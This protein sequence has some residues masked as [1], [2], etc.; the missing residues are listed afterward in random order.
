MQRTRLLLAAIAA[1]AAIG[2]TATAMRQAPEG[3]DA[4]A[5]LRPGG[6]WLTFD[7][8][9]EPRG[10][11]LEPRFDTDPAAPERRL[12]HRDWTRVPG[13]NGI[14]A[15]PDFDAPTCGD[16]HI[17]TRT[18]RTGARP[19]FVVR[20]AR[21]ADRLRYGEQVNTRYLGDGP[22]EARVYIDTALETFAYPDGS[23]RQLARPVARAETRDGDSIPVVLRTA[24]LL[25]GWGLLE[26]IEPGFLAH[27]HDPDDRNG[28]GIS[29]R[30]SRATNDPQGVPAALGWK[31]A[32]TSVQ[33]QVAAALHNDMGVTSEAPAPEITARELMLLTDYVRSLGVP[34]RRSGATDRGRDLF[35]LTGCADCHVSAALT[36]KDAEPAV[37]DQLIW[38][39]SDFM[40][41]DMGPGLADPGDAPDAAEWRTAPLW[42][43]GYAETHMP[44]RGFLH[45]GRARDVEEAV[46]WHGGEAA[47]SRDA[48][49]ALDAR[50]RALLLAYVRAL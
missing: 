26:A 23:E 15:G 47:A 37:A 46:L 17:E 7:G 29:G 24:P 35:G 25:Y 10:A 44:E 12:Y 20:P 16:C 21:V 48:F 40:L 11:L 34:D 32:H 6:M 3:V 36:R 1:S 19:P 50:D 28:N 22:A 38:P 4:A 43:V 31:G 5:L 49:S 42:G 2:A 30:I 33:G 13:P 18:A 9:A 14:S 8:P 41:H 27:F 39:Y 45:D